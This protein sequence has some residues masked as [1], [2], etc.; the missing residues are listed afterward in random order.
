MAEKRACEVDVDASK[1]GEAKELAV[2]SSGVKQ[3]MS[4]EERLAKMAEAAR[5]LLECMGEDPT[6]PGLLDTPMRMAKAMSFFT[7]VRRARR[8]GPG[9]LLTRSGAGLPPEAVG[10]GRTRHFRRV[11]QLRRDGA[12][13]RH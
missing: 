6:R 7:Q 2:V 4:E 10:R 12:D 8:Q 9:V 5:V 3:T 13:A 1:A 11:R